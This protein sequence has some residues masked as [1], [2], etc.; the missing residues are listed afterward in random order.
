LLL[1]LLLGGRGEGEAFFQEIRGD[2]LAEFG[3]DFEL[4]LG[5]GGKERGREG[6]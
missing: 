4:L 2:A 3:E 6:G 1:L 5:E